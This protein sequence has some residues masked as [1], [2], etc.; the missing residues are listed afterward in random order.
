MA[1]D[2]GRGG[3]YFALGAFVGA[4]LGVAMALLFTPQP[5]E[6]TRTTLKDK[7]IELQKRARSVAPGTIE[8]D[9]E[10]VKEDVIATAENVAE[11]LEQESRQE[12]G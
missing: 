3:N 9:V 5:G 8:L 6:E 4:A 10:G 1:N 11:E 7:G 2:N 12:A